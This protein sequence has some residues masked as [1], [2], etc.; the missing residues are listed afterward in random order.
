MNTK[1]RQSGLVSSSLGDLIASSL[2]VSNKIWA[3]S[4]QVHEFNIVTA[5][6]NASLSENT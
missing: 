5:Q 4:L 6:V 1:W 3:N 2:A